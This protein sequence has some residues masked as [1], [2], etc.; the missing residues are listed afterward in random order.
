MRSVSLLLGV[1]VACA[2]VQR[3]VTI[4][5]EVWQEAVVPPPSGPVA[6]GLLAD[7]GGLSIELGGSAAVPGDGERSRQAGAP[8]HLTP[9]LAGQ[10][11]LSGRLA[12]A[13]EGAIAVEV[14][15]GEP[16]F[17]SASDLPATDSHVALLLRGGPQLRVA[18]PVSDSVTIDFQGDLRLTRVKVARHIEVHETEV[19]FD[20]DEVTVMESYGLDH[21]TWTPVH[22]QGRFGAG[23][24]V[25]ASDA[26]HLSGGFLVQDALLAP[27]YRYD[28]W[29]CVWYASS[30]EEI[31][32][33]PE[34]P[35]VVQHVPVGTAWVGLGL[36]MGRAWL[37]PQGWWHAVPAD[38]AV[39][40]IAPLGGAVALRIPLGAPPAE[41]GGDAALPVLAPAQPPSAQPPADGRE[42]HAPPPQ[43]DD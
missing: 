28:Q 20:Y 31:C 21:E 17:A 5:R 30:G 32:P 15:P 36:R 35:P 42:V 7:R 10:L 19:T 18:A 3:V 34:M 27:G 11:R 14:I 39:V 25:R 16:T 13:V 2:P 9:L 38:E 33:G 40:S 4:E 12:D 22:L 41:P 43:T 37:L 6:T 29:T 23:V 8:G 24:G 1:L 26:V